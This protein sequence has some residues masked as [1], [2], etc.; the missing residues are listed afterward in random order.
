MQ[1]SN[2]S[3]VSEENQAQKRKREKVFWLVKVLLFLHVVAITSWALP[4]PSSAIS[5]GSK[6]GTFSD[7][8]LNFNTKYVKHSPVELYVLSTGLWQSWDMFA[9]SPSSVDIYPTADVTF[10]S[11][12]QMVYHYPRMYDLS[13]IQKYQDERYRKF[14]EHAN[15]EQYLY[16]PFAK[17]V[18]YLCQTDPS[19]PV[20]K[21]VLKRHFFQIPDAVAFGDYSQGVLDGIEKGKLTSSILLPPNPPVPT[22]YQD[23]AYYTYY[24]L[25]G[26]GRLP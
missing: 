12:K 7:R 19:D 9:P 25:T 1:R 3:P 26:E 24:P 23:Y 20:V 2:P 14:F 4:E 11:G 15:S 13:L 18:A 6:P 16:E 8:L 10:R 21:V 5:N 17:R 22:K